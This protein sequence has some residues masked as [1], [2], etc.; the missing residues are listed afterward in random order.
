MHGDDGLC[1]TMKV[2]L[3]LVTLIEHFPELG[4]NYV[5]GVAY[6]RIVLPVKRFWCVATNEWRSDCPGDTANE[7]LVLHLQLDVRGRLNATVFMLRPVVAKLKAVN[8]LDFHQ[9]LT[10]LFQ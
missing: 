3:W 8:V 6:L 7:H 10:M 5:D 9:A 2:R 1:V 4:H